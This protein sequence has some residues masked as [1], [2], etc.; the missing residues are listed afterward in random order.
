VAPSACLCYGQ[1]EEERKAKH[2]AVYG[3]ILSF[4]SKCDF[5]FRMFS[6]VFL[7]RKSIFKYDLIKLWKLSFL[8]SRVSE[9][10]P[11]GFLLRRIFSI[12]GNLLWGYM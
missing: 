1:E 2:F 11:V 8:Y 5:G 3:L 10:G 12:F 7:V 6:T 9:H 4:F